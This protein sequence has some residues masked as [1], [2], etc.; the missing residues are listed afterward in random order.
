M[1]LFS[2]PLFRTAC[3]G[4]LCC[5]FILFSTPASIA[6]D[7]VYYFNI[8]GIKL[9]MKLD[10]VI[11]NFQINK[12]KSSKDRYGVV[13]GFE[14]VKME[15]NMKIVLNFTGSK[16]LYRIGFTN[17]YKSYTRN[18]DAVFKL[19]KRKYG[20]P[21]IENI[22]D[23]Q[24]KSGNISACW[25]STCDRFSPITP[26]LKANIDYFSGRLKLT[27][28]DNRIFN[29][30]WQ[31]YKKETNEKKMGKILPPNNSKNSQDF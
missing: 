17:L 22:E 13:N 5:F 25:G 9:N 21:D 4:L 15:N 3:I 11:K 23:R 8:Q 30:D 24:G 1:L 12:V 27:L 26:A 2:R 10:K 18:S 20:D 7:N 29:T 14:I 6:R 28:T 16:R 31:K 19:L